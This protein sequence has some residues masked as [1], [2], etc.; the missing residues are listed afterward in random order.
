MKQS[1][2]VFAL[3]FATTL[4]QA[5]IGIG[6]NTPNASSQLDISSTSRGLLPPRMTA[7]QRNAISNPVA[8][9]IVWCNDCGSNGDIQIYNGTNWVNFN[10][11][12]RQLTAA[13]TKI[14]ADIDGEAAY[15]NCGWSV[16]IS[17]DGTTVAIGAPQNGG[18]GSNAGQVRV[19]KNIA[20]TWTQIGADIDGEA[21]YDNSGGSVSISSDGSTVAIGARYNVGAGYL[22]GHVRVYQNIGGNW[23]QIGADIDGEAAGDYFGFSVSISSDGTTVAIGAPLN[24]GGGNNAGQVRVYKN[25]AGTWTKIGADIDGETA[26]DFSGWSVSISSDGTTVAIGAPNNDG[27]GSNA[28]QVRVYQ[29]INGTW[30]KIGA[31]I[32]G[33]AFDNQSG[34]SVA[35]SSDGNTVAIGAPNND[36]GGS[37]AGQVR[38]YK[39]IAG[40][41]TKIGADIDGEAANDFSGKSVSISSDGTTVAI[42]APSNDGGGSNAGQVRVYQNIAGT[43]TKIV[44]DFDGEAADDESGGCVSISSEGNTVAMGA[45]YN[46]GGGSIAGQ[47]RVYK[48][49]GL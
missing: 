24:D 44:G 9:L 29:N 17:S 39:N 32:D 3:L 5:Q 45:I 40:T 14:G 20:G 2:L 43:W 18:N 48:I 31:D 11:G 12:T 35:I 30:T 10:G 41:W 13:T 42:G 23:T 25:I 21:A 16:S 27:G 36:G 8:G 19:Y 33:E 37:I 1:I 22:A 26:N 38:V 6:T 49:G 47:V 28:G 46:Y 34:Y 15:D 4:T 7:L